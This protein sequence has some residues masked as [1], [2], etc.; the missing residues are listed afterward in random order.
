MKD[1]L[2]K[3]ESFWIPVYAMFIV[4]IGILGFFTF[5]YIL[6]FCIKHLDIFLSNLTG[7]DPW[8]PFKEQ[9]K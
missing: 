8:K 4:F 5:F 2:K 3:Y 6:I 9:I 7:L 1:F